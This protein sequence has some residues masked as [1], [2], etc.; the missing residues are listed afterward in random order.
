MKFSEGSLFT[1]EVIHEFVPNLLTSGSILCDLCPWFLAIILINQRNNKSFWYFTN[2]HMH[3]R[4]FKRKNVQNLFRRE[5][6]VMNP[7]KLRNVAC[8]GA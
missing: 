8:N 3:V 5:I 4:A 6:G 1:I 2:Y 7:N